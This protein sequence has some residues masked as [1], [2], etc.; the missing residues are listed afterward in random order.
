[1]TQ[2]TTNL[3]LNATVNPHTRDDSRF[4][5]TRPKLIPGVMLEMFFPGMKYL[6]FGDMMLI[7][8]D[9]DQECIA[10]TNFSTEGSGGATTFE[11]HTNFSD[12]LESLGK[13][14]GGVSNL[15]KHM[16]QNNEISSQL[17]DHNLGMIEQMGW[18]VDVVVV[19]KSSSS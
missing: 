10:V 19:A 3:V 13:N 11:T 5:D 6:N 15:I 4:N 12:G 1:M 8:G 2:A 14:H 18:E 7:F 16:I 9:K 17:K